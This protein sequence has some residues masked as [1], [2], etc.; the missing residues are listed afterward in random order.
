MDLEFMVKRIAASA[1]IF[2]T[3]TS[4]LVVHEPHDLQIHLVSLL[5]RFVVT[6]FLSA[7]SRSLARAEFSLDLCLLNQFH[8]PKRNLL[9]GV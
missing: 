9:G 2:F 8:L 6:L 5:G 4:D 3:T 7:R 1:V